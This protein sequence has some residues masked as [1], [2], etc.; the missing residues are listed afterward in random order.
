MVQVQDF[1]Y[2]L[3]IDG[4]V[5]FRDRIYVLDD[6]DLKKAILREFHAKPYSSHPDYQ[7][8]LIVVKRLYY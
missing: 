3:T 7:K 1:D 5:R 6:S 4:L 2:R 8:Y